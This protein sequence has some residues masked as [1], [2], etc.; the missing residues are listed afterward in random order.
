MT[1]TGQAEV[2]ATLIANERWAEVAAQFSDMAFA[3]H[4]GIS[5]S[6]DDPE[7]PVCTVSEIKDFHLGGIGRDFVNGAVLSGMVDLA[8]GITALPH[9]RMMAFA[10]SNVSLDLAKPVRSGPFYAVSKCNQIIGRKLF[11]EV[12]IYDHDDKPCVFGTG[13]ITTGIRLKSSE[14]FAL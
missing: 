6:L 14:S 5:V 4:L 13:T 8:L 2:F 7:H 9:A 1:T 11:S 10:T 12:V 3:K